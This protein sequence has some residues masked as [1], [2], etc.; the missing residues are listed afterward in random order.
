MTSTNT[1]PVRLDLEALALLAS[2]DETDSIAANETTQEPSSE[3]SPSKALKIPKDVL[4]P[5]ILGPANMVEEP[6]QILNTNNKSTSML[7]LTHIPSH[8]SFRGRNRKSTF[9]DLSS[10]RDGNAQKKEDAK[11]AKSILARLNRPLDEERLKQLE[12]E[13]E[14]AETFAGNA[15]IPRR[16]DVE[17]QMMNDP[18]SKIILQHNDELETLEPD[19]RD[20]LISVA[21]THPLLRAPRPCVWIP[22]D[23]LGVSDDECRRTR[24]FSGNLFIENKGAYFDKR[25][26]VNVDRPPPDMSEFALVIPEL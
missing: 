2:D 3:A 7:D 26:K 17:A 19:E 14:E 9:S 6:D 1:P 16:R 11:A 12:K 23:E 4:G 18:I 13:L 15:F 5:S 8:H 24:E 20:M 22:R 25:W 10:N 21:F